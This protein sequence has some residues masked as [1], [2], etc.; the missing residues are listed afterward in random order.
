MVTGISPQ[1]VN[2]TSERPIPPTP[3]GYGSS[4]FH[5]DPPMV[6]DMRGLDGQEGML[7]NTQHFQC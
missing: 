1:E 5:S 7:K 4:E 6:V 3:D 2:R